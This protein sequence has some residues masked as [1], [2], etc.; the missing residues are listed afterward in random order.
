MFM[1]TINKDFYSDLPGM[2]CEQL[3]TIF[4]HK[5]GKEEWFDAAWEEYRQHIKTS[6]IDDMMMPY[7][8][9]KKYME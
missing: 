4:I 7:S 9:F 8:Y 2:V 1:K 5:F 3:D 6:S